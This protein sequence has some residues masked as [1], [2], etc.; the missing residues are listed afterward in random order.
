LRENRYDTVL[1]ARVC[2]RGR[3]K[4]KP[5]AKKITP[6]DVVPE[7]KPETPTRIAPDSATEMDAN[8]VQIGDKLYSEDGSTLLGEVSTGS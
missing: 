3:P 7:T 5:A 4:A 6:E 8:G 1:L 2:T